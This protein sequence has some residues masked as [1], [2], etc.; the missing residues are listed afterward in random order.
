MCQCTV[1]PA[2]QFHIPNLPF[3]IKEANS[4]NLIGRDPFVS[5]FAGNL[6]HFY[7]L[8]ILDVIFV[9]RHALPFAFPIVRKY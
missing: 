3:K 2:S 1:L 6:G 5:D 9:Q 4:W 7:T 8:T